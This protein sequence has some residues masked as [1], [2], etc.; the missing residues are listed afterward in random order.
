MKKFLLSLFACVLAMTASAE[1]ITFDFSD[2]TTFGYEKPEAGK[3]TQIENEGTI[4]VGDIT[5]S[6][7]FAEGSG[8]RF[9]ANTNSGVIDLRAYKNSSF[10]VST[11][12]TDDINKIE[13]NGSNLGSTYL[14][15]DGFTAGKWTG[16]AKSVTF[17]C[18][19]STVQMSSMTITVGEEQEEVP[20]VEMTIV[21]AQAAK[22]G[23]KAIVNGTVV[24]ATKQG[25]VI[26]DNT[27]YIYYY[28]TNC[29]LAVGDVVI[30]DG[31]LAAY[32]GFNQFN[33]SAEVEKDGTAQVSYPEATVLDGA[34]LDAWLAAPAIKYVKVSGELAISG[35]YYNLNVEGAETA[36]GSLIKP[37][38]ELIAEIESGSKVTVTG[39]AMYV[40]GNKYVNIAVT[41]LT[42]DEAAQPV[43]IANT[44][45][46]AYTVSEAVEIID[47]GKDLDQK[48]YV[49]GIVCAPYVSKDGVESFVNAQ[50]GDATFFISE[51]GSA[52]SQ[53]FEIYQGR[54]FGGE[55]FEE[56]DIKL[57]DE[58]I[59]Y[60]NLTKYKET[61]ETT[62][63][64]E[65][66]RIN[67][68]TGI[69]I[70]TD[71][72]NAVIFDLSG[73]RVNRA[74][75]GVFIVNGKKVIK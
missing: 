30:I 41:D 66:V 10:T 39:F 58:V 40:S 1:T 3:Y 9:F 8:L 71:A 22:A 61:Y 14:T 11:S 35:N 26:G 60:G 33:D 57:G 4:K 49:K 23:T 65:L 19:K 25:A 69:S 24:A 48:V 54:S 16:A 15:A 62:K 6:V 32:N 7:S 34:A 56:G 75:N 52:E 74:E 53:Q 12:G 47:A 21:E 36:A 45:E 31:P 13:I 51:D 73:R 20:S 37:L 38:D 50:Y 63:G 17:N 55:K 59:F 70:A 43:S 28:N 2:P 46:T 44:I 18:I 5:I 27:G 42:V 72:K 29:D 64:A 68:A 67:S